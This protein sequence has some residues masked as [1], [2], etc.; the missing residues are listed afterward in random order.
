MATQPT[1][2]YI[3][4]GYHH[5][6]AFV[7]CTNCNAQCYNNVLHPWKTLLVPSIFFSRSTGDTNL[8]KKGQNPDE[9]DICCSFIPLPLNLFQSLVLLGMVEYIW[10]CQP[11]RTHYNL[12]SVASVQ[13]NIWPQFLMKRKCTRC[14]VRKSISIIESRILKRER[15]QKTGLSQEQTEWQPAIVL[16]DGISTE[17]QMT[18]LLI[19]NEIFLLG[20]KNSGTT[21]EAQNK[22]KEQLEGPFWRTPAHNLLLT[23]NP[24]AVKGRSRKGIQS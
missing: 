17:N 5:Y 10:N 20:W 22:E 8:L 12:M 6:V 18:K 21:K 16:K 19:M 13:I 24:S 9:E 7:L 2:S 4:V 23:G 15:L 1:P 3:A 11:F 14:T